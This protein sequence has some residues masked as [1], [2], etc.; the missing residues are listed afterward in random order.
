M[1]AILAAVA[2]LAALPVAGANAA[3]RARWDTRVF[4]L[5]ARPGFPAHAYVHPNGR[6]YEGTYDNPSG[7]TSASRVFEYGGDGAL[8][9]SWTLAGQDLSK[10]HGV[11]VATS[12]ARGRLVL[13]DKSPPRALLLDPSTGAQ[14][15]YATF[16]AGAVPNYA[17]WGPDGSLYVTDY[18]QPVL[19]R[20]P[21]A[22]GTPQEW[23]RDARLDGS[24]FGATGILLTADRSAL[25]VGVQSGAG[26]GAGNPS[27]GN[28]FAIPLGADGRPG[29]PRLVWQS[30]PVD[31]P[32]GFALAKSGAIYVALL[33][34]NQLAVLSPAGA[35][36]ERFPAVPGNGANGS[37]VPF[38]SP[39]SAR[40]LGT[41]LM[42]ANQSYFSGD[43]T[44]QAVL[45][46]ETGEEGLPELIPA[47]AGGAPPAP[48]PKPKPKAKRRPC[49]RHHR[50][51][52][53]PCPRRHRPASRS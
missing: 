7:D 44:H 13:L 36:R 1:L 52:Y 20:V 50:P 14:T 23:L 9:R 37:P 17:A 31:G 34:V 38:D 48:K 25:L 6:V 8:L 5:V 33:A 22:G 10:A 27:A 12:D 49:T 3:G 16:P 32:D 18:E 46:V 2:T 15:P 11:Q 42:V 53:R 21:P 26:G 4:A 30:R 24:M 39:S 35:E 51:H 47:N 40:F 29:P 41:R 28:I 43:A 19:W 45:D